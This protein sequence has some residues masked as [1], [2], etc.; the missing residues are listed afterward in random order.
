MIKEMKYMVLWFMKHVLVDC[1]IQGTF[2]NRELANK[3]YREGAMTNIKSKTLNRNKRVKRLKPL[4]IWKWP[5]QMRK[6]MDCSSSIINQGKFSFRRWG[7]NKTISNQRHGIFRETC[8]YNYVSKRHQY[9]YAYWS[10]LFKLFGTLG[11]HTKQRQWPLCFQNYTWLVH[12][13]FYWCNIL[14][15]SNGI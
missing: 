15:C 10:Q 2:I 12:S 3:L 8:R 9:C 4:V 7:C 6:C 14:W 11:S 1:F 5:L 13:W